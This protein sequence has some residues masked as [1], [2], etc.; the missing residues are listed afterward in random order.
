MCIWAGG[1]RQCLVLRGTTVSP[2]CQ[3]GGWKRG[4]L[5]AQRGMSSPIGSRRSLPSW[6]RGFLA[7]MP[8]FLSSKTLESIRN[9]HLTDNPCWSSEQPPQLPSLSSIIDVIWCDLTLVFIDAYCIHI[10]HDLW[11]AMVATVNC[12]NIYMYEQTLVNNSVRQKLV[13]IIFLQGSRH[14][15]DAPLWTVVF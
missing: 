4:L 12:L 1:G 10:V 7:H 5:R 14:A 8:C 3:W 9:H 6:G 15:A 13:L 2:S 11:P